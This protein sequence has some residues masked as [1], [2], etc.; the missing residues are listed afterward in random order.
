[1]A[2]ARF[3]QINQEEKAAEADKGKNHA[4]TLGCDFAVFI[5][6]SGDPSGWPRFAL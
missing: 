4:R 2:P 5:R 3:V 6:P 1:L